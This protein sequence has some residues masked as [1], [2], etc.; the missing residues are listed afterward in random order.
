M[1]ETG[2]ATILLID[3]ERDIVRI[4]ESHLESSYEVR[5]ATSAHEGLELLDDSVDVVLLDRHMPDMSGDEV[6]TTIRDNGVNCRVVMATAIE[7]DTDLLDMDFDEYLV[8]P[9]TGEELRLAVERMLARNRLEDRLE[10]MIDLSVTLAT[11]E[12]K[13]EIEDL[14]ESDKYQC[15]LEEFYDRRLEAQQLFE[16][17]HFTD[18]TLEKLRTFLRVHPA[19]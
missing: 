11:L 6:L 17:N 15:L 5:T 2:A 19:G 14:E 1:P 16:D 12:S 9:L 3:D 4:Y 7:P 10:D 18:A 8:K 13:L